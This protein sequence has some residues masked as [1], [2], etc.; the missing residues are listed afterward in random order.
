M[1]IFSFCYR[2]NRY[3]LLKKKKK[4]KKKKIPNKKLGIQKTKKEEEI[5]ASLKE[6]QKNCKQ[7]VGVNK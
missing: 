3:F 5:S 1:I 4:K 2:I 6:S 7:T